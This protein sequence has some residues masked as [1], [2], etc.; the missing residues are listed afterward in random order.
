MTSPY[1]E[2]TARV[3]AGLDTHKPYDWEE[4][5]ADL[6]IRELRAPLV[7]AWLA[8]LAYSLELIPKKKPEPNFQFCVGNP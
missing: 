2:Y 7:D 1:D 8:G 3:I 5:F 4:P 6:R